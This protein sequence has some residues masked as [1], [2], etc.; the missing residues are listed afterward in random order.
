MRDK[1][2][3]VRYFLALTD[4]K[5]APLRDKFIHMREFRTQRAKE[6]FE[7]PFAT[8]H[9]HIYVLSRIAEWADVVFKCKWWLYCGPELDKELLKCL[10]KQPFK[11]IGEGDIEPTYY[12]VWLREA[13]IAYF[14]SVETKDSGVE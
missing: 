12:D 5:L 11:P 7:N 8:G 9:Q 3:A 10:N 14:K 2:H 13:K 4:P 6:V 1:I